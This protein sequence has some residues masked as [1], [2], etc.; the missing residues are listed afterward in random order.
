MQITLTGFPRSGNT[1]LRY[2]LCNM[3]PEYYFNRPIHTVKF[4]EEYPHKDKIIMPIRNPEDCIS[5]WVEFKSE[6]INN[7][8]FE[9]KKIGFNV[10][11]RG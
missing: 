10:N 5:S 3:Y 7:K 9:N 2:S 6:L 4:L 8:V 11:I 1:F